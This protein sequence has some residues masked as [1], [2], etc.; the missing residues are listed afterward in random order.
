MD[1]QYVFYWFATVAMALAILFFLGMIVMLFYIKQKVTDVEQYTK[2]VVHKA[3]NV[4]DGISSQLR[5]I[6]NFRSNILAKFSK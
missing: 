5:T 2:H 6:A 1:I 4:V 3:D